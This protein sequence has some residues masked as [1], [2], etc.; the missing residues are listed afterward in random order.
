[1]NMLNKNTLIL[2]CVLSS[3]TGLILIYFAAAKIEPAPVKIE[4]IN[5]ELVGR[6]VTI[7]GYI[8]YK[9]NHP[10]GHIF[11]TVSYNKTKIAVPLFAGF[12][13]Q[14][15]EADFP[16]EDLKKGANV[17]VTGLVG[18]YKGELQVVPRKTTDIKILT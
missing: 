7:R 3:I 4:E 5:S 15:S 6:S 14:L 8:S 17:M 10:A 1:M 11:L 18:E 13:N 16:I 12:V 9:T 2:V